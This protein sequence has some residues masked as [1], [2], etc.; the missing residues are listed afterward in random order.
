MLDRFDP[1]LDPTFAETDRARLIARLKAVLPAD[2]LLTTPE[3]LRVY[4]SDGLAAYRCLPGLVALPRTADEVRLTL[5]AC[6]EL[7]VPVVARGAGTGLS[8][9]ALPFPGCVLL[10]LSRLNNILS[11]DPDARTAKVQPGVLN[12]A[13]SQPA[14]PHG[15]LYA[16]HPPS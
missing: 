6:H 10:G 12:L 4:E 5:A 3:A 1:K 7:G 14:P 11:L 15:L 8:G 13:I 2:G 9:G 16:P